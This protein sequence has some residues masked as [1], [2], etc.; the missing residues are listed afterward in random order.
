MAGSG[1]RRT[2]ERPG[3]RSLVLSQ[4]LIVKDGSISATK[5]YA[6]KTWRK[7]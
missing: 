7:P 4:E 5:A 1:G 6:Q 3:G 2:R